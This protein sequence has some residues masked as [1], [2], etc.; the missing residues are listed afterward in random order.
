MGYNT[1]KFSSNIKRGDIFYIAKPKEYL[2]IGSEQS[3]GRPAIVVSNNINN[4]N[5]TVYEMVYLTTNE[6]MSLPTHVFIDDK[7]TGLKE[8]STALCEQVFSIAE[9]RFGDYI[10]TLNEETMK[11]IDRALLISLD[12]ERYTVPRGEQCENE[13][14]EPEKD[15]LDMAIAEVLKNDPDIEKRR[16]EL[17]VEKAEMEAYFYKAQYENLLNKMMAKF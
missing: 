14:T 1:Y 16:L 17:A 11:E 5:S 9:E 4:N 3:P 15:N 6:K 12:L 2:R 7:T 10:C 13:A 8:P